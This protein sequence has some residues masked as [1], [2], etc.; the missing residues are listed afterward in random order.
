MLFPC[1][2]LNRF[3]HELVRKVQRRGSFAQSQFVRPI[4][5][6]KVHATIVPNFKR[7]DCSVAMWPY[8]SEI[9]CGAK[10]WPKKINNTL[11]PINTF[12]CSTYFGMSLFFWMKEAH[13]C[14]PC[15]LT[16]IWLRNRDVQ[17]NRPGVVVKILVHRVESYK[18]HGSKFQTA[19]DCS[20]R[21]SCIGDYQ[22]IYR[23]LINSLQSATSYLYIQLHS[24]VG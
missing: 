7:A 21:A 16:A 11:N 8:R 2:F 4:G 18:Q 12:E 19:S 14:I 10:A 24:G 9:G 22:Y 17:F 6:A 23:S 15:E 1:Y 3:S 20:C 13:L 5:T